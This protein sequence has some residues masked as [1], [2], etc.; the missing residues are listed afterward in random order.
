MK[1]LLWGKWSCVVLF[2]C[3]PMSICFMILKNSIPFFALRSKNNKQ[4]V[5]TT[6]FGLSPQTSDNTVFASSNITA[7]HNNKY[8]SLYNV[9]DPSF[10]KFVGKICNK[11]SLLYEINIKLNIPI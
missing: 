9:S 11:T 2:L 5:R 8:R 6:P 7:K 10:M 1:G 3:F 4:R